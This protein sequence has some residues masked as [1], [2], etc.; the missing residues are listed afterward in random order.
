MQ[1]HSLRFTFQGNYSDSWKKVDSL[2]K[3]GLYE[4]ALKE[5]D[6]I[7]DHARNEKN[8]P[9][10]LR[11]VMYKMKYNSYMEEEDH[12]LA[13]HS[14][15]KLSGETSFPLKQLLHSV[16]AEVYWNYYAMNRW[17]IL[18]RT[19]TVNF[20]NTDVRTWDLKILFDKVNK[21]FMQSLMSPDSLK[22]T[23]IKD[24]KEE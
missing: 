22:R 18:E 9:N 13:I 24:F 23:D 14:L 20:N 3:K 17:R 5:V 10:V 11:A 4:S 15:D 21:E 6:A 12:I 8:T 7:F 1:D 2:E 19:Q 16:S